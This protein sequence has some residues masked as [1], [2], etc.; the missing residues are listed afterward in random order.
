VVLPNLCD[1]RRS[2]RTLRI[3]SAGASTGQE[4]YSIAMQVMEAAER[5]RGW[6]VQIAGV[7]LSAS[8]VTQAQHGAYNQFE[9]QR[10]LP[11]RMLLRHFAKDGEQWV[12]DSAIRR[13]VAFQT[14][15]LL[16]DLY[17]LGRFDVIMCRNVLTYFD[18]Q[19][20]L[21]IL[22]KLARLLPEDGVLYVGTSET[23][24]GVSSSFAPVIPEQGIYAIRREGHSHT[25]SMAVGH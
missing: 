16:D 7:D 14:W 1:A 20:K 6:Q 3:L 17:P 18:Q 8:A 12:L 11:V 25:R 5:F 9:V 19:T 23:I 10:G 13:M 2:D 24:A 4:P 22:Q 15:N 21:A